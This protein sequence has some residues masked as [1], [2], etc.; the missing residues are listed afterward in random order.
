M[1][2]NEVVDGS[3]SVEIFKALSDPIRWSIM[4]QIADA[5]ELACVSLERTLPVSKPTISYH[6]KI[7]E[8]ADLISVRKNGRNYYYSLRDEVIHG[9][10]D[11]LWGL[12]PTPRPVLGNENGSVSTGRRQRRNERAGF[13]RA[14]PPQVDGDEDAV[15]AAILTW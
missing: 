12:A 14:W 5:G 9:L 13:S 11:A 8:Q 1:A 15:G 6:T 10:L 3:P 2:G 4:A 7:L